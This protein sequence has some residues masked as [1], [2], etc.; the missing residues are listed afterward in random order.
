[1]IADTNEVGYAKFKY[2]TTSTLA[3]GKVNIGDFFYTSSVTVS[4]TSVQAKPTEYAY[5][6]QS[7]SELRNGQAQVR[8]CTLKNIVLL[9][10]A[11]EPPCE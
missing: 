1:L 4:E 9:T 5:A 10:I 3:C 6:K 7:K 2:A 8:I 11:L